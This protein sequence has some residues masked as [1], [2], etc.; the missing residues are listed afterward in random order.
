VGDAVQVRT[1]VVVFFSILIQGSLVPPSAACCGC[2][3]TR[4]RPDPG[5][6]ASVWPTTRHCP[7]H[8]HHAG[9]ARRRTPHQ[10]PP[11]DARRHLD[12]PRR[13]QQPAL[14]RARDSHL[15]AG[16]QILIIANPD[17][18]DTLTATFAAAPPRPRPDRCDPPSL[19]NPG[20]A[21]STATSGPAR[22]VSRAGSAKSTRITAQSK[23]HDRRQRPAVGSS[24]NRPHIVARL[25]TI[26]PPNPQQPEPV[27]PTSATWRHRRGRTDTC[28][29]H[30][31][32]RHRCGSGAG[33]RGARAPVLTRACAGS[34]WR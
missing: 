7:S 32:P 26:S 4:A 18:H 24:R 34:L 5:H 12:Q 11:V 23:G 10:R 3:C 15:H 33:S 20:A 16:D 30:S 22:Q 8:H 28:A 29:Y 31:Q 13:A 6:S 14:A 1:A 2:P 19:T 17:I 9:R 27:P 21:Q 25:P